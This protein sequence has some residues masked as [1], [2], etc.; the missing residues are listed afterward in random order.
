MCPEVV[1]RKLL[2]LSVIRFLPFSSSPHI[3]LLPASSLFSFPISFFPPISLFPSLFSLF[4]LHPSLSLPLPQPPFLHPSP[5]HPSPSPPL[6]HLSSL[7]AGSR[8]VRPIVFSVVFTS[9]L[10]G[11]PP[12]FPPIFPSLHAEPRTQWKCEAPSVFSG[13]FSQMDPYGPSMVFL[14]SIFRGLSSGVTAVHSAQC[15]PDMAVFYPY[16]LFL[17]SQNWPLF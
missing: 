6:F 10:S 1:W 12:S 11:L 8:A 9:P 2:T 16:L 15:A 17:S 3:F 5:L 7:P 13:P 14:I 4:S